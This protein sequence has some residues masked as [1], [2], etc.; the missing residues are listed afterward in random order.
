MIPVSS[1]VGKYEEI[2]RKE[3]KRY[4][5]C[6]TII[7][8]KFAGRKNAFLTQ[9]AFPVIASYLDHVH[10]IENKPVTIHNKSEKELAVNLQE[11][12]PIYKQGIRLIFPDIR[13][14]KRTMEKELKK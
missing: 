5:K 3:M 1:Q 12:L 2:I 6:N 9:N 10:T 8:G 7:I 11:V 4:V 14:I 13:N